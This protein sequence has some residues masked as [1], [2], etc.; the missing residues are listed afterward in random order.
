MSDM[1]KDLT[2]KRCSILNENAEY[3]TGCADIA[4]DVLAVDDEWIKVAFTDRLGRRVTRMERTDTLD[5]IEVF[6]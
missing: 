6:S 5:S 1:L 4:C 3:L 2:G